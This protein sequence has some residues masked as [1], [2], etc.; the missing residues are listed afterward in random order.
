[1]EFEVFEGPKKERKE[2]ELRGLLQ[3]TAETEDSVALHLTKDEFRMKMLKEPDGQSLLV[4]LED[5][6]HK[7]C[8]RM[9]LCRGYIENE[10]IYID[11]PGWVNLLAHLRI[12]N[13]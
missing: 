13:G 12:V 7:I 11:V 2:Q 3:P 9:G 5:G 1:M 10:T 8:E 4:L 6:E